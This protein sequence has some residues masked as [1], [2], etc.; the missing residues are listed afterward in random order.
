MCLITSLCCQLTLLGFTGKISMN[1][2]LSKALLGLMALLIL[3]VMLL[4]GISIGAGAAGN[5]EFLTDTI[6]G[7]I[8]AL[9][10]VVIALLTI[11]LAF[12][13]QAMRALQKLQ[14]DDLRL[15]SIRPDI[16]VF[17][18]STDAAFNLSEIVVRNNGNGEAHSCFSR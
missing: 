4:V 16:D 15:G 10:T 12:E 8:A 7:W 2:K 11:V 9:A 13:T 5:T 18:R 1:S 6:S 14:I 3:A 17:L